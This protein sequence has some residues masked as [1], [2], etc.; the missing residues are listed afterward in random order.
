MKIRKG[1]EMLMGENVRR[2]K[3]ALNIDPTDYADPLFGVGSATSAGPALPAGSVHPSPETLEKDCGGYTRNQPIIGFGHTYI[4]GAGG[5]K[6]YGNY[7]LAPM[8]DGVE[9]ESAKRASFAVPGTEK[10][11][12]YEYAVTLEN[13]IRAKVT[14]AHNAAIHTFTFP[15]GKE[16]ALLLDIAR[17]LDIEACMKT[18]GIT[19]DPENKT[20]W[21]GGLYSGNWNQKDWK[22][23]FVMEFDADF[24]E[25]GIFRGET[26]LPVQG[27]EAVSIDALERLGMYVKFGCAER[28]RTV[29]VKL[30]VSFVSVEKAKTFLNEQIPAFDYDAVREAAREAWRGTLGVI[31]LQ[32]DDKA[33][34]RRFYTA[35]YHMNIQPRDRVSDHGTWDDF[36]TVWDTWKTVFPMYSLLYP[37]KMGAVIESFVRRAETNRRA[38]N[39]IVLGDEYSAGKEFLAGQGGNDV[40]NAIVDAYLKGVRLNA[41]DWEEVYAV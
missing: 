5:V 11:R 3:P 19:V 1:F 30:A 25:I 16:A 39:G 36:H 23:Y 12:C 21:G 4:S 7:L 2:E 20:V 38:G 9:L 17:K 8:V 10:A 26:L 28:E 35:M 15:A 31:E 6:C 29:R 13:G 34:L 32:T 37:E 14:P 22:M 18:G 33:L 24:D 40:D 27:T 41:R